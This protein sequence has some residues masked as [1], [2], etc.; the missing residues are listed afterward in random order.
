MLLYKCITIS[1]FAVRFVYLGVL[2][3]SNLFNCVFW[4]IRAQDLI[5]FVDRLGRYFIL[6]SIN[7]VYIIILEARSGTHS[8]GLQ[9]FWGIND[10]KWGCNIYW[11]AS[12]FTWKNSLLAQKPLRRTFVEAVNLA[13]V[14]LSDFR[15]EVS[16]QFKSLWAI[17]KHTVYAKS[18][19]YEHHLSAS[20]EEQ[21]TFVLRAMIFIGWAL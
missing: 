7:S 21:S 12:R 19:I 5:V 18:I 9:Q 20:F 6:L 4:F 16:I 11:F 10:F 2:Q 14:N 15:W 17:I 1:F 13:S 8:M 3:I